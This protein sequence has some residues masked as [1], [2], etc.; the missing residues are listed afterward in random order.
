MS[1]SD[2]PPFKPGQSFVT[3]VASYHLIKLV[4]S[5]S[6]GEL[7]LATQDGKDAKG[8]PTTRQVAMKCENMNSPTPSLEVELRFYGRLKY[9]KTLPIVYD[10]TKESGRNI[11]VMELLG[12][13]IENRMDWC[14]RRMPLKDV[15]TIALQVLEGIEHLHSC[16]LIHRDIKPDNFLFGPQGSKSQDQL[17]VIDLGLAKEYKD[18]TGKHIDFNANSMPMGTAR[19]MSIKSH[20]ACQQSRRDDLEAV[21]YMLLY[22]LKGHMPWDGIKERDPRKRNTLILEKKQSIPTYE[23]LGTKVPSVFGQ[24]L[25]H[26]KNLKFKQDPPYE[27]YRTW[28]QNLAKAEKIKIDGQFSWSNVREDADSSITIKPQIESNAK[29]RNRTNK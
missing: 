9:H 21:A 29:L 11:L 5:G 8:K 23:L 4:G 6:F 28:F 2:L 13:S 15:I 19:Y 24:Y 25:D 14:H 10:F 18:E 7:W 17:R 22:L 12:K 16:R 3:P 26:V 27:K 20:Q 1:N